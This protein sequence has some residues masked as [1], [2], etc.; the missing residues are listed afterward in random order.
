[1]NTSA[2]GRLTLALGHG[3]QN[4]MGPMCPDYELPVG[5]YLIGT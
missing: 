2:P 1:M 3:H 4:T 5:L